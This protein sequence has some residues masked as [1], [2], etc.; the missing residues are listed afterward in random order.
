MFIGEEEDAQP[1]LDILRKLPNT[2]PLISQQGESQENNDSWLKWHGVDTTD[3]V[4]GNAF[5]ASRLLQTEN[6]TTKKSRTELAEAIIKAGGGLYHLVASKGV[7]EGDPNGETSVT[8]AWRKTVTHF[9]ASTPV[10]GDPN[11]LEWMI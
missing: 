8:P 9:V 1:A 11:T 2:N 4:G 5:L 6:F 3:P 10:S 7:Q